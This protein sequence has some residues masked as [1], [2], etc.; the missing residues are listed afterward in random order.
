M[1]GPRSCLRD[2]GIVVVRE[3]FE[4]LSVAGGAYAAPI[5]GP[6][7]GFHAEDLVT[8]ASVAKIQIALAVE[9]AIATG[10]LDGAQ[11]RTLRPQRRTAGPVGISLLRDE[12]RM[13]VRDLVTLMLTI[14]DNVAMDELVAL[15]GLDRINQLTAGLGLSRTRITSDLRSMLD[16]LARDAG[17]DGYP[18]LAAHDPSAGPPSLAE[19]RLRL[20][21]SAALDPARGWS[22]TA[23]DTVRLLQ[24]VWTDAAATPVACARVRQGMAG[25]LTRHRIA[26]GFGPDVSVAAKSGGLMGL[27]RNEA[28]VV[29]FP[30]GHRYA[31]AVFTRSAPGATTDPAQIDAG[32]GRIARALIDELRLGA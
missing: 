4:E 28:G 20:H 26:A 24:A 9:D 23:A 16:D 13:S 17:F 1:R 8:P 11:Q 10:A 30:D 19:V 31:V 22:T 27:V 3:I 15:V 32:I 7:I 5:G 6:G 25:Q 12:V 14:S 2:T 18:P 21:G 29:T